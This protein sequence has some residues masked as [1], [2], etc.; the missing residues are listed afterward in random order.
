MAKPHPFSHGSHESNW[1]HSNN[2]MGRIAY[3]YIDLRGMQLAQAKVKSRLFYT[4]FYT[5]YK[6]FT[7]HF[8]PLSCADHDGGQDGTYQPQ[9]NLQSSISTDNVLN[10]NMYKCL[11]YFI[12]YVLCHQLVFV[13]TYLTVYEKQFSQL[14]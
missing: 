13:R 11:F 10:Y 14:L 9:M 4:L 3:G 12:V 6:Y 8:H 5:R 7:I 1:I 2:P